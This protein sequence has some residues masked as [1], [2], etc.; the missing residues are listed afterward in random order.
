MTRETLAAARRQLDEARKRAV[1][2]EKRCTELRYERLCVAWQREETQPFDVWFVALI[3]V[4]RWQ[5]AMGGRKTGNSVPAP[6]PTPT[7][8]GGE[9]GSDDDVGE[10]S[11]PSDLDAALASLPSKHTT[12]AAGAKPTHTGNGTAATPAES[13]A[14]ALV[15]SLR[16][17]GGGGSGG[18]AA[19]SDRPTVTVADRAT[20]RRGQHAAALRVQAARLTA[21]KDVEFDAGQ[22]AGGLG[23]HRQLYTSRMRPAALRS[24]PR[25][26]LESQ[27]AARSRDTR[28]R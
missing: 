24:A 23:A 25:S 10:G 18:G 28:T 3:M 26:W 6:P 22:G 19:G 21:G 17:G 2:S 8:N 14:M 9:G 20:F 11:A 15:T 1:A 5:L 16:P 4:R 12:V 27:A 7:A 13:P